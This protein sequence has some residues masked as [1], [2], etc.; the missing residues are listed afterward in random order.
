[1]KYALVILLS[2]SSLIIKAQDSG[3]ASKDSAIA[4]SLMNP[5]WTYVGKG[6]DNSSIYL[7]SKFT[8]FEKNAYATAYYKAWVKETY[9]SYTYKNKIYKNAYSLT[10]YAI[11]CTNNKISTIQDILYN[12]NGTIINS[13]TEYPLMEDV[14]PGSVGEEIVKIAAK[15]YKNKQP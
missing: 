11:D 15:L 14:I 5:E 7:K 10:L 6:S 12:S 1:M 4:S 3:I 9:P 13:S 2:L 8:S